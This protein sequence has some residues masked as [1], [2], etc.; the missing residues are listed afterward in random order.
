MP[1][2]P[3]QPNATV[4]VSRDGDIISINHMSRL[5]SRHVIPLSIAA[6]RMLA[7]ELS[8]LSRPNFSTNPNLATKEMT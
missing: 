2:I 1:D 6:A 7:D 3:F 8:E 4:N 5:G